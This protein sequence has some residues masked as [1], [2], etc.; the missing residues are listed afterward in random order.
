MLE[1]KN[2]CKKFKDTLAVDNISFKVSPGEIVGLLVENGAGKTTTLRMISTMLK[3]TDG[4]IL[5]NS[6]SAKE[7]P[8]KVRNQVGILFGGDLGLY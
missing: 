2:V 7:D 1:L 6:I 8:E 4:Q 5:V 3:I